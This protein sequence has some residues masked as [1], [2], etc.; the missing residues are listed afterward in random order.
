MLRFIRSSVGEC[1]YTQNVTVSEIVA[2]S[3]ALTTSLDSLAELFP[4]DESTSTGTNTGTT[5][6]QP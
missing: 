6:T 4:A 2:M 5:T 1:S 3:D